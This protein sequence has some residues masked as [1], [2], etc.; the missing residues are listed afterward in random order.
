MTLCP[1]P[2]APELSATARPVVLQMASPPAHCSPVPPG[3]AQTADARRPPRLLHSRWQHAPLDCRLGQVDWLKPILKF[4]FLFIFT[5]PMAN[6]AISGV[7]ASRGVHRL[8]SVDAGSHELPLGPEAGRVRSARCATAS[9]SPNGSFACSRACHEPP[10]AAAIVS[11]GKVVCDAAQL[12][13][14]PSHSRV[15]TGLTRPEA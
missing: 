8:S 14:T 5:P 7:R 15:W 6:F 3:Q 13:G 2:A 10:V 9:S 4:A 1:K 12:I 11:G